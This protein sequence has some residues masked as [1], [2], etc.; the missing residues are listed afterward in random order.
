MQ[1]TQNSYKFTLESI[2]EKLLPVG[3]F[4]YGS[5]ERT[6][7]TLAVTFGMLVTGISMMQYAA[8]G[9]AACAM[10]GG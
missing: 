6:Y 7:I 8:S 10:I 2:R 3:E 1:L 4:L 9:K 5:T